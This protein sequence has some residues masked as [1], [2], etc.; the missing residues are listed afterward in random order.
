MESIKMSDVPLSLFFW[1]V[2]IF[3][4]M[5][6]FLFSSKKFLNQQRCGEG[7]GQEG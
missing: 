5:I 7:K 2:L 1:R 6:E 4:I 3:G